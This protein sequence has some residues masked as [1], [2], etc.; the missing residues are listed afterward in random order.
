[1]FF[2]GTDTPTQTHGPGMINGQDPTSHP[3]FPPS[4]SLSPWLFCVLLP[5][6]PPLDPVSRP[7]PH[8]FSL[9]RQEATMI[10]AFVRVRVRISVSSIV[11]SLP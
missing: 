11:Y 6:S 3:S 8:V 2:L 9:H 7:R 4:L 1:M 5:T 10:Y